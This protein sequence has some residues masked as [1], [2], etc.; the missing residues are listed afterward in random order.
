MLQ[1]HIPAGEGYDDKNQ[2]FIYTKETTLRLEHSLVALSKWESKW[3]IP[4]YSHKELTAE[5]YLDYVRCMTIDR[6]I[7]PLVYY[8]IPDEEMR[9][10]IAYIKDEQ[11]ATIVKDP[12]G[13]R[14]RII[15]S[16]LIYY[17]MVEYRIPF[18]CEKWHL[19]RLLMLIRVYN[20]EHQPPKKM[21]KS[22]II[23]RNKQLN[24]QRRAAMN[25]KG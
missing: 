14:S 1:I 11:T 2:R 4:F 6:G 12:P 13:G 3:K 15:T 5:Q 18:E 21:S 17:W 24:A 7:D 8:F 10:I 19:S 9:K 20:A 23:S 22:E 16:E 25:S